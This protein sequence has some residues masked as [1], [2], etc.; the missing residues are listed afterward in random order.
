VW[1]RGQIW[2]RAWVD[3]NANSSNASLTPVRLNDVPL[4]S[5]ARRLQTDMCE[6]K[7]FPAPGC[8]RLSILNRPLPASTLPPLSALCARPRSRVLPARSRVEARS[9]EQGR[10]PMAVGGVPEQAVP[11]LP[12]ALGAADQA[13]RRHA[14]VRGWA[15]RQAGSEAREGRRDETEQCVGSRGIVSRASCRSGRRRGMAW[16][17]VAR[18]G[19]DRGTLREVG[20]AASSRISRIKGGG[21]DSRAVL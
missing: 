3:A 2:T 11:G 15:Q 19:M 8:S 14:V 20:V 17:G 12:C 21:R 5:L 9:A 10:R 16:H 6:G 18:R 13:G 4:F 7:A 1:R